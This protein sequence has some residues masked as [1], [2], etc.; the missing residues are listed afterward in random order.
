[1]GGY[2]PWLWEAAQPGWDVPGAQTCCLVLR[3]I[4][5]PSP[6]LNPSQLSLVL[7]RFF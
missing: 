1:M 2:E 5:S 3:A 4:Y 6:C 7:Q